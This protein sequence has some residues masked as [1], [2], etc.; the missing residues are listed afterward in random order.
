MKIAIFTQELIFLATT[1]VFIFG[2]LWL[3]VKYLPH[4]GIK[5]LAKYLAI[6]CGVIYSLLILLAI[7]NVLKAHTFSRV[8]KE[9]VLQK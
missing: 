9:V 8:E 4:Q 3:I 7:F 5:R 1:A 2:M 6:I